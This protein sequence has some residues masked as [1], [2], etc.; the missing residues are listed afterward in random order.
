MHSVAIIK[1]IKQNPDAVYKNMLYVPSP[2]MWIT[3]VNELQ[4]KKT[5]TL[6]GINF[7]SNSKEK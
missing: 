4:Q 3:P 1:F 6:N 7:V 2:E 5:I